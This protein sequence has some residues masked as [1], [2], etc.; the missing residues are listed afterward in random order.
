MIVLSFNAREVGGSPKINALKRLF[1]VSR[2]DFLLIQE[3]MCNGDK[4]VESFKSW[5][6]DWSFSS[7]E[8]KRI[9]GGLITAWSLRFKAISSSQIPSGI[10]IDVVDN[11]LNCPFRIINLYGPYENKINF[12]NGVTNLGVLNSHNIILGGDLNFTL[13]LKEVWGAHLHQDPHESFFSHW[14]EK[15]HLIDLAPQKNSQTWCNGKNGD[16]LVTKYLQCF[17]I[18][19]GMID[20]P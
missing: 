14:I 8:S 4:G 13:S 17:L 20:Q 9:Y 10:I 6:K 12:W 2:P 15:N 7:I 18:S 3:T 16:A 1:Q 11:Y 19:K 5:L